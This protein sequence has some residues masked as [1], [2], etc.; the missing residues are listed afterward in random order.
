MSAVQKRYNANVGKYFRR[1]TSGQVGSGLD[2]FY[3]DFRNRSIALQNAVDIVVRQIAGE[4][5][6]QLILAYRQNK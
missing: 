2:H 6:E 5:T 3:Q 1:V 4:D